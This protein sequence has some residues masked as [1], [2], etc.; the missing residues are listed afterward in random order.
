MI[1][2]NCNLNRKKNTAILRLPTAIVW[3]I[4]INCLELQIP[5]CRAS[6]PPLQCGGSACQ[7][8]KAHRRPPA[9]CPR[10]QRKQK[11][12]QTKITKIPKPKS[13]HYGNVT[14]WSGRRPQ[15]Q[16]NPNIRGHRRRSQIPTGRRA[17]LYAFSC[18]APLIFIVLFW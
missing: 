9:P 2:C 8:E 3:T 12:I 5:L 17:S 6:T 18:S 13:N 4:D 1:A 7:I 15:T 14:M 16:N 11:T 10:A